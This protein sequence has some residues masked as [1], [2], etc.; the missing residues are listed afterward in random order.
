MGE[1]LAAAMAD[2]GS[3]PTPA[4]LVE[5]V[6]G[7]ML[8]VYWG[9]YYGVE[10]DE[11]RR[12]EVQL[13][14]TGRILARVLELDRGS[15]AVPRPVERRVVGT[16]RDFTVLLCALAHRAG[17]PARARCGF[18]TY[19]IEDHFEDHW[20][21]ELWC[22]AS[23]RWVMVDAQLDAL[24]RETLGIRFD[25]LDVPDDQFLV[26][27]RAWRLCRTGAADPGQFGFADMSGTTFVA[28]N[29]MRDLLALNKLELLPWDP[30]D[31]IPDG[32]GDLLDPRLSDW[33]DRAASVVGGPAVDLATV[34][35]FCAAEG[36]LDRL[37]EWLDRP[38]P[39][40]ED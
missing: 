14:A 1:V 40:D 18:A 3:E 7:L 11:G 38:G 36:L 37:P 27:G 8:H 16:C 9:G 30:W 35:S 21:A 34:R 2:L 13:R 19:F 39:A 10:F 17:I 22:A 23:G 24:Q 20:V 15:L 31:G 12:C 26:G 6:Q 25:P 4:R 5:M 29:V 28:G 32:D 33:Y